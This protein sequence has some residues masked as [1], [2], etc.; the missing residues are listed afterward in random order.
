MASIDSEGADTME[1]NQETREE[2]RQL[3]RNENPN[4]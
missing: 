2:A 1:T 4:W 3:G